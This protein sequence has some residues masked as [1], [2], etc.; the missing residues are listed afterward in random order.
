MITP[1]IS[2]IISAYNEATII[3]DCV[4]TCIDSLSAHFTDYELILI[5][6]A[7]TDRTGQIMDDLA[8][9]AKKSIESPT[10]TETPNKTVTATPSIKVLH[11][12]TNLNMGASIQRGMTIA[13]KDY[14]TFNAA[15]LP[16]N[17]DMYK[18]LVENAPDADMIVVERIKYSGTSSWRRMSSICNRAII[19]ILFPHLKKGI[20]DTNYLQI[21]RKEALPK[22]MPLAKDPIFTW[23]EMIFRARYL[24]MNVVTV[25]ADYIPK[26]ERK[27]AFG[28]PHDI[29]WAL[30]EMLRFRWQLWFGKVPKSKM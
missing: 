3:E 24:G 18:E 8:L 5:N 29:L 21:T 4:Q 20:R 6:D 17:P 11:N 9:T 22:I 30:R 2:L 15:D 13:T 12:E 23:P 25:K 7:S 16:L 1:G 26:H 27:G 14:V 10:A 19:R 28:K